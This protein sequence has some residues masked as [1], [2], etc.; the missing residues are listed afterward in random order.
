K[1]APAA[2]GLDVMQSVE[3]GGIEMG[4]L[5]D[6]T[7]FLTGRSLA[8]ICG[9]SN[10]T[11]VEWTNDNPGKGNRTRDRKL[12]EILTRRGFEG[13]RLFIRARYKRRWI[14]AFPD[15]VCMAFLE[16]YACHAEGR[17][18]PEAKTNY[19]VLS[20]RSLRELLDTALQ[21]RS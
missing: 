9:V 14:T 10:S 8:K 19:R 3:V 1:P 20:R 6:G 2:T 13:D 7:L 15:V 5:T 21:Q 11:I 17:C 12:A 16:Y 18:T 4:F